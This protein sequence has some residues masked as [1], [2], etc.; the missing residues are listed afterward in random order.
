MPIN[1]KCPQCAEPIRADA[2][3]CRFCGYTFTAEEM[4]KVK[5]G[6][7]KAAIGCLLVLLAVGSCIAVTM[8]G[9]SPAA[10]IAQADH[11]VSKVNSYQLTRHGE[12]EVALGESWS[13]S[14]MPVQAATVVAN[15]GKSVKAGAT[16]M[17]PG[18]KTITFWFTAPMVDTYGKESRSKVLQFNLRT[19]DL[20]KVDYEN[21][22]PQNLLEF[23]YDLD[24][25]GPAGRAA[26]EQYCA[27]TADNPRFCAQVAKP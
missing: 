9:T 21:V 7:K 18:T 22:A 2:K 4:A 14:H 20:M 15:A 16:D 13:A 25:G 24:F 1:K 3:V 23:A 8:P 10:S 6:N 12:V 19:A 27:E 5:A 11:A 26:V 17:P